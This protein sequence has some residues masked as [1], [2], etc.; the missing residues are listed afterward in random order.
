[1]NDRPLSL[2]DNVRL[3]NK[4]QELKNYFREQLQIN[5]EKAMEMINDQNLHFST[6]YLLKSELTEKTTQREL[7][8]IY[9][10][11]LDIADLLSMKI[12]GKPSGIFGKLEK[13]LR[14]MDKESISALRWIV[15]TGGPEDG[16]GS[17][18]EQLIERSA[19]FLIKSIG[20]TTQL[21]ALVEMIFARNRRK[22]LIHE[23]VWAFFEAR[24]PDSLKLLAQQLNSHDRR[25][26][27]LASRL[28]C[29]IPGIAD[30]S[31]HTRLSPYS[32]ASGWL[33]ENTPFLCYTG[34]NLHMS[35]KPM[36]YN[37]SL[38]A[39]YLCHPISI[40]TGEPLMRFL[41]SE[42]RKLSELEKLPEKLQ[43]RLADFSWMLYRRNIYQWN[44]WIRLSI[45]EQSAL[46]SQMTGGYT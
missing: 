17:K 29:F 34:E 3:S 1:M 31:V 18:Y 32:R 13:K 25:D 14:S 42:N 35:N 38:T 39:K 26:A 37:V 44:T 6:L 30:N 15:G 28:L 12:L 4:V 46:A 5:H 10:K 8:P 9:R 20:D 21:P 16:L 43:E 41:P 22:A 36:S 24:S 27:E 19:A 33:D 7:D 2:L 40:D 11:A 45:N 23:L